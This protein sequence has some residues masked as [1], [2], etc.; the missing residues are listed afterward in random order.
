MATYTRP[1]A[2]FPAVAEDAGRTP[3]SPADVGAGWSTT[4]Q[5]RPPAATF[6]AKDYITSSAVKYLLRLGVAEYSP[7]ESYQG[8]GLATGS[9]GSIYWNLVACTG[10]DPVTDSLGHWEKTAIR[11]ADAAELI[12]NITGGV[13]PET[14]NLLKG[15]GTGSAADSGI[16]HDATTTTFPTTVLA[17]QLNFNGSNG[18]PALSAGWDFGPNGSNSYFARLI[19]NSPTVNVGEVQFAGVAAGPAQFVT[20]LRLFQPT[21]AGSEQAIF[22][23]PVVIGTGSGN[24]R[25]IDRG[26]TWSKTGSAN[27]GADA[28]NLV[29]N[30]WGPGGVYLNWE[31]GTQGVYFGNGALGIAAHI[32]S[33]GNAL[34]A[35]SVQTNGGVSVVGGG[36]ILASSMKLAMYSGQGYI[37]FVGPDVNTPGSAFLRV[38]ASDG[39]H[40]SNVM[41]IHSDGSV[42]MNG[43]LSITG[44]LWAST[45]VISNNSTGSI[46][47]IMS[48]MP[49][50]GVGQTN[51]IYIGA[52]NSLNNMFRIG[53]LFEGNGVGNLAFFN[54]AGQ[55]PNAATVDLSNNWVFGGNLACGANCAG[56]ATIGGN[57]GL[58]ITWNLMNGV[59]ETD[60]INSNGGAGGGFAWYSGVGGAALNNS[61][62]YLM[63]LTGGGDLYLLNNLYIHGLQTVDIH[64]S[65]NLFLSGFTQGLRIAGSTVVGGQVA[66]QMM[67]SVPNASNGYFDFCGADASTYGVLHFRSLNS[68]NGYT[69]AL[70][71][72]STG[73]SVPIAGKTYTAPNIWDQTSV[74]AL[75]GV[76]Q[77]TTGMS[78]QVSMT[79]H[80]H[81]SSIGSTSAYVSNLNPPNYLVFVNQNNAST[82]GTEIAAT[83][84]VPPGWFYKV[85]AT[86]NVYGIGRW[87]EW[88]CP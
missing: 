21:G 10:I 70:T 17:K 36:P 16:T 9:N 25:L 71:L 14:L 75:S 40:L 81:G 51:S 34:F 84:V 42:A 26:G 53:F 63:Y 11:R 30:P 20:Y 65:G 85:T 57:G 41:A 74:R 55:G 82:E 12:G 60:F 66:N 76:Y 4:S 5:T 48:Q 1:D 54:W 80:V 62:Q 68:T 23:V 38:S 50:M 28:A 78:I 3:M 7:T 64:A 22:A 61:S 32:D 87:W 27:I 2:T 13:I 15:N 24:L 88:T 73:V 46:G 6:N 47:S 67:L 8:L 35:G 59:G 33:G 56:N 83:F 19:S 45:L 31:Q 77:N 72:A 29:I 18:V 49:N 58:K 86:G 52:S 69:E 39:S 43:S 37:D 79:C 44:G